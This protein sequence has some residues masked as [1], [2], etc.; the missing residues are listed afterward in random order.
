LANVDFV[1]LATHP[2]CEK[3]HFAIGP[4][5]GPHTLSWVGRGSQA[6][7]GS[8]AQLDPDGRNLPAYG[9]RRF[10]H[11]EPRLLDAIEKLRG[12]SPG[13]MTFIY[14][15]PGDSPRKLHRGWS[16]RTGNQ[17]TDA[18]DR[19]NNSRVMVGAGHFRLGGGGTD[20]EISFRLGLTGQL[21]A[22]NFLFRRQRQRKLVI[23]N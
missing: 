21:I 13:K 22:L 14:I 11:L 10:P 5:D 17:R 4:I 15:G 12:P 2:R 1:N 23:G 9:L 16:K 20:D 3:P 19:M 8:S 6:K 18:L 7:P